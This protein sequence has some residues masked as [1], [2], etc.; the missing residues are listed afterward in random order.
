ML[1]LHPQWEFLF[2][3][4]GDAREFV[5]REFKDY[6]E[7]Y[8]WCPR[9][10]MKADL[11]RLLVVFR[12][13]GFYLDT[14][15]QLS[16]K[17]NPLCREKAVFAFEHEIDVKNFNRRYPKWLRAGEER[18]TLANYAF[19]AEAGHP[20]LA[21]ILDELVY[22]TQ[23]FEAEHCNDLDILHA[24]GPDL[25]TSVY[26]RQ[27]ERWEDV[28]VLRSKNMGLGSYG[29]HLVH[30]GWRQDGYRDEI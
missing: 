3:S 15:L 21:A 10:V 25:V 12:Q 6:I 28:K 20:F 17:L 24:T 30:G 2:Y 27:R 4:D 11:F 8:D 5:N 29:V 18:L 7:L 1:E 19:G 16:K 13:G 26:Y 14:D 23:T 9:P 22:R